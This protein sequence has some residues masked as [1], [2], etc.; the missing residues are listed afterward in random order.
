M[1]CFILNLLNMAI[2][3][4]AVSGLPIHL[5]SL[6]LLA[7]EGG[8]AQVAQVVA[9]R[10]GDMKYKISPFTCRKCR[11]CFIQDLDDYIMSDAKDK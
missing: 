8:G 10:L 3:D 1:L 11:L 6:H 7:V 2:L 9:E 4:T 5:L